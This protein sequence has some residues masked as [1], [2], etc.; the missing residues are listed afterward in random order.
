[1]GHRSTH[2]P[3]DSVGGLPA[4]PV[5]PELPP[6]APV[7]P[8]LTPVVP[9]LELPA[10]ACCPAPLPARP[11]DA[12]L[13][14]IPPA[15]AFV[16]AT[17]PRE[18][19]FECE[20]SQVSEPQEAPSAQVAGRHPRASARSAVGSQIEFEWHRLPTWSHRRDAHPNVSAKGPSKSQYPTSMPAMSRWHSRPS[21]QFFS[22]Q[23]WTSLPMGRERE[24]VRS[25]MKEASFEQRPASAHGSALHP[26]GSVARSGSQTHPSLQVKPP[27]SSQRMRAQPRSASRP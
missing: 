1:M 6:A 27:A 8:P 12:P 5:A 16:A 13:P 19:A 4:P 21:S 7:P 2:R 20:G 24:L 18:S 17:Q 25:Q 23:P 22:T 26:E 15:P 9:A 3:I 10:S 11:P 14:P